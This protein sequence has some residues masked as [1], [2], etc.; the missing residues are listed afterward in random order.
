MIL[1]LQPPEWIR[2]ATVPI[3]FETAGKNLAA[4][5]FIVNFQLSITSCLLSRRRKRSGRLTVPILFET[6]HINPAA[7]QLSIVN[8]QLS[9]ASCVLSHRRNR[10]GRLPFRYSLKP[11]A[12]TI[13]TPIIHCQSS[14]INYPLP[15]FPPPE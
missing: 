15:S 13:A 14:I 4:A 10:S 6:A 3:L 12:R 9:I 8:Y 2:A 5:Q 11:P 1:R 7:T